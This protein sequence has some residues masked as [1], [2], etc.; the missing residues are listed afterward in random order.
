MFQEYACMNHFENKR[1]R[2]VLR[3]LA[4]L[5]LSFLFSL[6]LLL[7]ASLYLS[8]DQSSFII[9][10]AMAASLPTAPFKLQAPLLSINS[11]LL[12]TSYCH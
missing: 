6:S 10:A 3:V 12:Q 9:G 1:G 2:A 7:S 8:G 4:H 5:S 11:A